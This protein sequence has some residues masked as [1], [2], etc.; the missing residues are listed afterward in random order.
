M[1]VVA[2]TKEPAR[3]NINY[4]TAEVCCPYYEDDVKVMDAC[5]ADPTSD[6]EAC[7]FKVAIVV[8][9]ILCS[10]SEEDIEGIEGEA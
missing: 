5:L 6:R 7:P 8:G 1:A 9:A 2:E 10:Y 3:R 4:N